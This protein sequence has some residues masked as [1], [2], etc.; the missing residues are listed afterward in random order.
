MT[1]QR[2]PNA[3][4]DLDALRSRVQQRRQAA[5]RRA[6]LVKALPLLVASAAQPSRWLYRVP[7]RLWLHLVVSLIV[8]TAILLS[9][10]SRLFS[11]PPAVEAPTTAPATLDGAPLS[12]GPISLM[13]ELAAYEGEQ[14]VPDSAFADI[15]ALPETQAIIA[16]SEILA[17]M[18]FSSSVLGDQVNVR[19]GPGLIYDVTGKLSAGTPLTLEGVVEDWFV[20]RTPE[21]QR[22]WIAAELVSEASTAQALLPPAGEIPPPPPPRIATVRE[23]GLSVR[24]GPGTAYVKLDSLKSGM[25]IDL[26]SRY[27]EW[28]EVRLPA[29]QIG[30]VTGEYLNVAEGVVERLEVLS[31]A[32]DPNPALVAMAEGKVNLRRG[33]GTA[34]PRFSTAAAGTQLDLLGQYQDWF[35]IRTLDG[36]TAWVSSEVVTVSNYVAR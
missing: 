28:F 36:N 29:G 20:G 32:P 9:V 18:T 15:L 14:P 23:D 31:S 30:W 24:D 13:S 25:T 35:K 1:T 21:G 8:P 26:L 17:P 6:A 33:P 3:D 5:R 22:V 10:Q 34:F 7:A 2:L 16:R 12:L 4:R 11:L 27:A 19:S